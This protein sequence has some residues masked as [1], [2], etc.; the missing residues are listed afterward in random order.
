MMLEIRA[1]LVALATLALG[2]SGAVKAD[3]W[4]MLPERSSI[5]FSGT[6]TGETFM[7]RFDRFAVAIVFDPA[8]PEKAHVKA[9]VDA[10][11]ASTGD[12]QRDLALAGK[13]WFNVSM[14]QDIRFEATGF[15]HLGGPDYRADGT[16]S[17]LGMEKA[18]TLPFSLKIEDGQA[19][20]TSEITLDRSEYGIGQGLW[21]E[22][23]WVGLN[24]TVSI[25]I[26]AER[27]RP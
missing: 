11:S 5:G 24:V 21:S 25:V 20:M 10:G 12:K 17:V 8:A 18:L 7:G 13:D 14:F 19:L 27:T 9:V 15:H 6:Q 23:K 1:F 4:T 2:F 22:G 16:L 26:A 3:D